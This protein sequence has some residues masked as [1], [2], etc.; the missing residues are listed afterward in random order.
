MSLEAA[1]PK[2]RL[3]YDY[4]TGA[5]GSTTWVLVGPIPGGL[6][7]SMT[8]CEIYDSSTQVMELKADS[9]AGT[10]AGNINMFVLPGGNG[11]IT[12]RLDGGPNL[13]IRN[14]V[15]SASASTGQFIINFW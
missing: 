7:S 10:A 15:A 13:Y 9:T 1:E 6:Q 8:V 4:T 2:G 5:V 14:A 12:F 11:R 3:R